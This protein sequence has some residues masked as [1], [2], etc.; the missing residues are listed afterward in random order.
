MSLM[1][2]TSPPS[3]VL[4]TQMFHNE[5]KEIES[6]M[7]EIHYCFLCNVFNTYSLRTRSNQFPSAVP[8]KMLQITLKVGIDFCASRP[9]FFSRLV[10]V[11]NFLRSLRSINISLFETRFLSCTPEQTVHKPDTKLRNETYLS[12]VAVSIKQLTKQSFRIPLY[13]SYFQSAC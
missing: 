12:I 10:H 8:A 11:W 3:T 5:R 4:T 9:D 1:C 6:F 7:P 13:I 2:L